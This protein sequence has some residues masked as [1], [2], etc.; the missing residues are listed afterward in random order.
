MNPE[1]MI[2]KNLEDV[3]SGLECSAIQDINK[4]YEGEEPSYYVSALDSTWEILLGE[5][6]RIE[7]IFLYINNGYPGFLGI[8]SNLKRENILDMFGDPMFQKDESTH[9]LLGKYGAM[10]KYERDNY[11]I[12]IEH[13]L[14]NGGVKKVTVMVKD[15][16]V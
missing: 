14:D 2:G 5:N 12:H 9:A 15:P 4:E 16:S 7:T 1:Q 6:N 10:E 3:L 11:Y 8:T 13:E